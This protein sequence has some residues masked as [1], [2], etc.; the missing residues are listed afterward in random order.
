MRA[1]ELTPQELH[2]MMQKTFGTEEGKMVLD[3]MY[4]AFGLTDASFNECPYTAAHNEG[5]RSVVCWMHNTLS[6]KPEEES[7]TNDGDDHE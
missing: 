5:M 6:I 4:A 7:A 1:L 2:E 3:Y